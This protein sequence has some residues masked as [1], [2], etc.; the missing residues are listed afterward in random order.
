MADDLDTVP[1]QSERSLGELFGQLTAD[2]GELIRKEIQLARVE[3]KEEAQ[4]AGRAG[5]MLAG[6]G[7]V[8]LLGAIA[9]TFALAWLL[10]D[11]MPRALAFLIV[12]VLWL[13]VAAALYGRGRNEMKNINP[14]PAETVTT[15]KEDVQWARAQ[16]S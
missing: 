15:L 10:D 6:A 4:R 16:R 11:W 14:V 7:V 9:L 13:I 5:G 8:A 2:S 1:K 12:G 3:L